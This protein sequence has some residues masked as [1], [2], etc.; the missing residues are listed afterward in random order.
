MLRSIDWKLVTDVS[1]QLIC[2]IFMGQ[3]LRS[4]LR[5]TQEDWRPRLRRCGGATKSRATL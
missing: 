1:E 3:A 4:E 5:N 2:R